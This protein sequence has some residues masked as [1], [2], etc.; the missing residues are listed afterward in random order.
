MNESPS[1][2]TDFILFFLLMIAACFLAVAFVRDGVTTFER[3]LEA[4][5]VENCKDGDPGACYQVKRDRDAG[6]VTP[7]ADRLGAVRPVM[8][9]GGSCVRSGGGSA[10]GPHMDTSS[11]TGRGTGGP[12][13]R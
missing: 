12:E 1:W 11:A 2:F 4:R 13:A 6:I 3:E 8:C 5:H 9:D 10:G 7:T